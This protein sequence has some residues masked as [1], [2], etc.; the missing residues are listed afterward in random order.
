M[1]WGLTGFSAWLVQRLSA[2][3]IGTFL[4]FVVIALTLYA[5]ADFES[6]R[7]W[8][9]TPGVWAAWFMF[10]VAVILHAWIGIRDVILDYIRPM[11]LRLMV[12]VVLGFGLLA[13]AVL[14]LRALLSVVV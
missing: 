6:W 3:Y 14:A 13:L 8:I 10:F 5:P 4:L 7:H 2:L 1:N 9:A 12:L 11:G